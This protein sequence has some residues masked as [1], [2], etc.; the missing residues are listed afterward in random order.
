MWKARGLTAY[1]VTSRYS[2]QRH[3]PAGELHSLIGSR[4][5]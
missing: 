2:I 3:G 4:T 1:F 5:I